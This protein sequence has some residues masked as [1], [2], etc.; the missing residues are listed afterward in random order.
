M[1]NGVGSRSSPHHRPLQHRD[2]RDAEPL[3]TLWHAE[4]Q[5]L[6]RQARSTGVAFL[7]A[8]LSFR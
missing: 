7:Y 6:S 8:C 5:A 1:R 4:G 2:G 3:Y